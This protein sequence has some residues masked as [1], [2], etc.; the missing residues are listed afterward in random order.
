VYV[1]VVLAIRFF[2]VNFVGF[3]CSVAVV[4]IAASFLVDA[5]DVFVVFGVLVFFVVLLVLVGFVLG[6]AR[7]STARALRCGKN[8]RIDCP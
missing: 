7:A 4:E 3:V 6:K 1:V 2:F 8:V 5:S